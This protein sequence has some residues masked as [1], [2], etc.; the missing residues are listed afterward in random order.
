MILTAK[1]MDWTRSIGSRSAS[2]VR[3][4]LVCSLKN[5]ELME[6]T[7]IRSI[8][9]M[10][11]LAV[12]ALACGEIQ[13]GGTRTFTRQ[14]S[15]TQSRSGSHGH[16]VSL[17]GGSGPSYEGVAVASTRKAAISNACYANDT[18]KQAVSKSVTRGPNGMFYSSVLYK[19]R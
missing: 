2:T 12:V 16:F 19:N 18:S 7:M 1:N 9:V 8:R 14:S 4:R 11:C 13:A 17:P 5:P 10:A 3:V 15:Q 6:N